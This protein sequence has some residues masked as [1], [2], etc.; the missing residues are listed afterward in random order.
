VYARPGTSDLAA[1]RQAFGD[2]DVELRSDREPRLIL[3]LGANV[4]YSSVDFACRFPTARVIA[5]EPEPSNAAI[6]R[7]NTA[8]LPTVD[9]VE[10][11][12]WPTAGE[13]VVT[14]VGKGKWGARARATPETGAVEIGGGPIR[15]VTVQ[16]LLERAG[17]PFADLVS[18]DIEGAE[19]ELFSEHTEWVD[20]VGTIAIELHDRFR[21]GCREALEGAL[22]RARSSFRESQRGEKVVLVREDRA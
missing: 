22:A 20:C 10:A 12:V 19:L 8:G 9:V 1:F 13:L 2:E 7:R 18:V 21:P 15:A 6:L 16:E 4:G 5:V 17:E 11:G 14:D 3:D